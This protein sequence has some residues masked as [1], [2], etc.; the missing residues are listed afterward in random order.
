MR[1]VKHYSYRRQTNVENV[2]AC[3]VTMASLMVFL[4]HRQGAAVSAKTVCCRPL[5]GAPAAKL[6]AVRSEL[7][8][9]V[10]KTIAD[11]HKDF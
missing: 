10:Y 4:A 11:R 6:M 2:A 1:S 9:K 8:A 7:A 3:V 5:T